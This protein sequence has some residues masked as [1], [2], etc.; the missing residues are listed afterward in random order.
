MRKLIAIVFAF[1]AFG[2]AG[3]YTD[4]PPVEF[5]V[6]VSTDPAL[7]ETFISVVDRINLTE[8]PGALRVVTV[9]CGKSA[10]WTCANVV[11]DVQSGTGLHGTFWNGTDTLYI[12]ADSS[13]FLL[14]NEIEL[15]ADEIRKG[16]EQ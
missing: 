2:C 10:W 11:Q 5:R 12:S 6:P 3:Q 8:G 1:L 13:E 14:Q 7:L 9:D 15:A 4:A 16:S